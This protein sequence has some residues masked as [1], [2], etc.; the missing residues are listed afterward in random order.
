[1]ANLQ[2]TIAR[3]RQVYAWARQRGVPIGLG[4]DLWGPQAQRLQL[5]EFEMRRDLDTP[6]AIL[7]SATATNAEL[8]MHKGRLGTL[9]EGAY[10]DLLVVDGDPL[11]DIGVLLDPQHRLK[12]IMKDGVVYKNELPG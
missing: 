8:L 4:T 2:S 9:A 11:S 7:R 10:A 1:M 3:G 12:F 5:R 6:A